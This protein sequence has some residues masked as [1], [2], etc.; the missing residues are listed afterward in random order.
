[1]K[2]V[3]VITYN[4][5]PINNITSKQWGE[6]VSYMPKFGWE[7]IV[8]T[9]CSRG[10]LSVSIPEGNIIRIGE[11][12][13]SNKV[14]VEEEGLRG[15]PLY[16]KPIYFLY[17]KLRMEIWSI[18]RFLFTWGREVLK[19]KESI[20][21]INPSAL[22]AT[23][24]PPVDIWLGFLLSRNLRKPWIADFRDPLSLWNNSKFP[25]IKFFDKQID[26]FLVRNVNLI[27]TAGP[28][29][30]RIMKNFYKKEVKIIYN[31]F[32]SKVCIR[33]NF[34]KNIQKKIVY[35]AGRF[36]SH[37]LPAVNLFIDWLAGNKEREISLVLRS[38]GPKESNEEI[39]NYARQQ[40][41]IDK[42]KLLSPASINTVYQEEE[43]ADALILFGDLK[44][45]L[46]FPEG[47][48][49]GK[50]FEYLPLMA[51]IVVI[52]RKDSDMG[53]ILKITKRGYLVSDDK[54]LDAA[55]NNVLTDHSLNPDWAEINKY[56][57]ESQCKNLC[58]FLD[59]ITNLYEK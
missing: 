54:E 59:Q 50:L 49:P 17:K 4:F 19:Y 28:S 33:E 31:G 9:T 57:F 21:N 13:D 6:L 26:K 35:Y 56:S 14:L 8:L 51:P 15:I 7:P 43:K 46:P 36:H 32:D 48:M 12:C 47:N 23:C 3:L 45:S 11:H 34:K 55:M 42:V 5:P 53:S 27:T 29:I 18:D 39:L 37:R 30:A 1:M 20:K 40:G 22:V 2:R 24:Y 41:T 58:N 10:N 38:I 16:L 52:A 25:L 44:G